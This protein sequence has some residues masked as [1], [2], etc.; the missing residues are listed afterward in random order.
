MSRGQHIPMRTCLGCGSNAPQAEL[1]RIA[2]EPSG[3]LRI[4][5]Q[6]RAGG[7]GGYL[8]PQPECWTRFAQRKGPVRSLRV[9]IDRPQRAALIAELGQQGQ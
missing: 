3:A 2:R 8:H 9:S 4:D 6:R 1:L 5:A 7:R